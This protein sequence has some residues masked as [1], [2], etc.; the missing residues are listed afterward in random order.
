[1]QVRNLSLHH[2]L[3]VGGED[4]ETI[5]LRPRLP[6]GRPMLCS[7]VTGLA[8][9]TAPSVGPWR[10]LVKPVGAPREA[11]AGTSARAADDPPT[12][13]SVPDV[14]D[15]HRD[16]ANALCAPRLEGSTATATNAQVARALG[17]KGGAEAGRRRVAALC[18]V[19]LGEPEEDAGQSMGDSSP[20]VAERRAAR[21][22]ALLW[23]RGKVPCPP[24]SKRHKD[25]REF[26]NRRGG[27]RHKAPPSPEDT[28]TAGPGQPET[29]QGS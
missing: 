9:V 7:L 25:F 22:A 8:W 10:V 1:M 14:P 2:E 13:T 16:T 28:S 23:D 6:D 29:G 27:N 20:G 12:T 17:L 18:A 15:G 11:G 3:H 19:Y 5:R 24:D 26:R 21:V 4:A